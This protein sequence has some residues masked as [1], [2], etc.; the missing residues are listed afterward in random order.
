MVVPRL[1][2]EK[3]KVNNL[4]LLPQEATKRRAKQT[5]SK[6]SKGNNKKK[7]NK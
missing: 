3:S 6:Q 1:S 5:E 2:R 7:E 4:I